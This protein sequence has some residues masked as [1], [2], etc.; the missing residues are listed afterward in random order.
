MKLNN[1][2]L[3][4]GVSAALV[5]TAGASY[6]SIRAVPG[7]ALLVPFAAADSGEATG[8]P[9]N[10]RDKI[11]TAV[12]INTPGYV[13]TDTVL[14]GYTMPNTKDNFTLYSAPDKMKVHWYAF[15]DR[16]KEITDGTFDMTPNDVYL[17]SPQDNNLR[18]YIGYLVFA[19]DVA[20]DG[21]KA[22]TF[23]MSGNAFMLLEEGCEEL[24]DPDTGLC[25]DGRRIEDQNLTLPV[26]PMS[27]G[28]DYC[29]TRPI[30]ANGA[31][32]ECAV[33]TGKSN[34]AITYM[35]NVVAKAVT[36][37][38]GTGS[39]RNGVGHVSPL[40]AG[41]RTQAPFSGDAD[42]AGGL[43]GYYVV[44]GL[45]SHYDG[46]WTHVFWF[47][48]NYDAREADPWAYD[49]EEV[50]VSCPEIPM[51]NE[52]HGIVY[53]DEEN[54]VYDLIEGFKLATDNDGD[55]RFEDACLTAPGS[56]NCAAI[57][58]T[59]STGF[60]GWPDNGFTQ[61]APGIGIMEYTFMAGPTDT[62]TAVF[63]Q[64]LSNLNWDGAYDDTDIAVGRDFD[65]YDGGYQE[66]IELGKF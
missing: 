29:Q 59:G 38:N 66:M 60:F 17:W 10:D 40:V 39:K 15:D 19:D 41:V 12:I 45:F 3:S 57:C 9:V 46:N 53:A 22:A 61:A 42:G 13:G 54:R 63:F 64:F 18:E 26:V 51:P 8:G 52:L 23:G 56:S 48:E 43:Y 16:S 6:A 31:V 65:V 34:L 27:D 7:E 4:L 55:T 25:V 21:T 5:L 36:R 47:S 20:K 44:N 32:G 2:A 24:G 58:G 50:A 28:I 11:Y 62:S 1:T 49:D 37:P 30:G 35:N 33:D 14:D